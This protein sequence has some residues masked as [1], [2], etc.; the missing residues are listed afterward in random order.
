MEINVTKKIVTM[1][2]KA[3]RKKLTI[4]FYS[5]NHCLTLDS[6]GTGAPALT[7]RSPS[8]PAALTPPIL[9]DRRRSWQQFHIFH[10]FG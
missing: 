1:T 8:R 5:P 10:S 7:Q 4:D 3:L 9:G 2:L 6:P